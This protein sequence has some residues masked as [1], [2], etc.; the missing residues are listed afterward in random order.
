MTFAEREF[1]EHWGRHITADLTPEDARALAA[2][3]LRLAAFAEQKGAATVIINE[4][5]PADVA[6]RMPLPPELARIRDFDQ[7]SG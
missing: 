2:S 3:L 6:S 5:P 7:T 4:T 1:D